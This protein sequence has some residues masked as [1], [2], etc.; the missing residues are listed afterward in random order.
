MSTTRLFSERKPHFYSLCSVLLSIG[1]SA[2]SFVELKPEAR[3]IILSPPH[4]EC[5]QLG[6]YE[7][8]TQVKMMFISR[9]PESLA[10]ELQILAQNKA[11]VLGANAIWPASEITE[12][13]RTYLFLR[14]PPSR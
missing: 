11:A 9:R 10:D 3:N 13:T 4:G 6:E 5:R 1:I 12:G 14:C 7:L 2:C 8:S